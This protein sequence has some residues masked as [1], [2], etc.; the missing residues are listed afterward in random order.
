VIRGAFYLWRGAGFVLARPILWPLLIWPMLINAAILAALAAA[1]VLWVPG[2]L[3]RLLP[4][5]SGWGHLLY[6]PAVVLAWVLV[7][8]LLVLTFYLSAILLAGPFYGRLSQRMLEILR[9]APV[10]TPG[11][12]WFNVVAPALNTLRRLGW[13]VL[14]MPL[15]F[16]PVAGLLVGPIIGSFFVAMEFLDFPLDTL[17][18]P[19]G[20]AAR[21]RYAWRHRW[22]ALGFG[23]MAMVSMAVPLVDLA[24]A[25]FAAAGATLFFHEH[26]EKDVGKSEMS[27][28]P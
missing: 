16:V 17:S 24:V 13:V 1:A 8:L 26:P 10:E 22:E 6:W 9:G 18:P 28:S 11:G 7:G 14:L 4:S 20:F 25:P 5:P 3:D 12:L 15:S 21:R 2:L 23:A 27:E 19:P